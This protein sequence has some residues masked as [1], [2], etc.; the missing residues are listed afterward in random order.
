MLVP[1][2]TTR[3]RKQKLDTYRNISRWICS[4]SV[5][6]VISQRWT[7]FATKCCF[8]LKLYLLQLRIICFD[9]KTALKNVRPQSHV[10]FLAQK[11]TSETKNTVIKSNLQN[12][13]HRQPD[14]SLSS[15]N[16]RDPLR[17]LQLLAWKAVRGVGVC[18]ILVEGDQ[19]PNLVL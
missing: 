18:Q 4:S 9:R 17:W 8:P 6:H 7:E 15:D 14:A 13:Y 2:L 11:C 16:R 10:R 19:D 1:L 3:L 5:L 12:L